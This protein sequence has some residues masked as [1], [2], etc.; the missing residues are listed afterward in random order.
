LV[1]FL[2]GCVDD[3]T[4][5]DEIE[6][7]LSGDAVEA[8]EYPI[9]TD[10]LRKGSRIAPEVLELAFGLMRGTDVYRLKLLRVR[11]YIARRLADRGE[12]VTIISMEGGLAVLTD[13]EALAYNGRRF[14]VERRQSERC[15]VRLGQVDRS[16]LSEASQNQLDRDIAVIGR[17][18][19]ADRQA[20]REARAAELPRATPTERP[21]RRAIE[22]TAKPKPRDTPE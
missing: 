9:E 22:A 18:V 17:R 5:E 6:A 19:Q 20:L 4:D 12:L 21:A 13:E 3:I 15:F 2:G 14:D 16:N 8:T 7:A 11:D 1:I 10:G